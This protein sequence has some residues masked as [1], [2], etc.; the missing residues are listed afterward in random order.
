MMKKKLILV[1]SF[2]LVAAT[3][4]EANARQTA[5]SGSNSSGGRGKLIRG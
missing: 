2:L 3:A 1:A 5:V 4:L